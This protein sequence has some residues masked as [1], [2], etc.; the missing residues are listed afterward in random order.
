M[1]TKLLIIVLV[2]GC[3]TE[4]KA[5]LQRPV[6]EQQIV[7]SPTTQRAM[8]STCAREFS[9][10]LTIRDTIKVI[11][12][13]LSSDTGRGGQCF[14]NSEKHAQWDPQTRWHVQP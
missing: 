3:H 4:T 9:R 5:P 11:T 12:G 10:A 6:F 1:K 7:V 14:I 2:A 13:E 8:D